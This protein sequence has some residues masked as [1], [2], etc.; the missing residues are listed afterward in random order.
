MNFCPSCGG[1]VEMPEGMHLMNMHDRICRCTQPQHAVEST[2][3]ASLTEEQVRALVRE[4]VAKALKDAKLEAPVEMVR[5]A[6][7]KTGNRGNK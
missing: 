3:P 4:E 5:Q 6:R 7:A 1:I 2:P